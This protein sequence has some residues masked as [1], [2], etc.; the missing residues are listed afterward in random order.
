M[1]IDHSL[2]S[3]GSV[4]SENATA[5]SAK[6]DSPKPAPGVSVE[7]SSLSSQM[8]AVGSQE[9]VDVARV[10]KIKQAITEGRFKVNPDVVADRL[11]ETVRELIVSSKR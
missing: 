8:Q 3:P 7:L 5:R 11:L 1:K 4:S 6:T 2:K 9:V 10:S